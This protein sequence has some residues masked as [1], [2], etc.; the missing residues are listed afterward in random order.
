MVEGTP[1]VPY[2][3]LLACFNVV[4]ANMVVRRKEVQKMLKKYTSFV[5]G[6]SVLS[7]SFP[8]LGAPDFTSPPMKPTPTEDGPGRSIF[9]PED[10]VFCGHP[11]FKNLVKNIRGRRGEKVAINEDLSALGEGDM[12]SAAK[13][14]HIYM[15]HMGFGMG[16]CCLQSVDDRTAEERGL[17][18][19]K[20]SKWRIAKSRYDSTDC[21]IYPCSVAYNDIPLQYDEA[22]YQQLRDGD[23]DEPLAKHIA[24]MF[25]R[26][27]L[28]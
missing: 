19:L 2:G 8:S 11:R 24:H 1:G 13:P 26:D 25:I 7:I 16:C 4:E 21:Y 3:G 9:W 18:P 6:E 14:D 23:I 20:N 10:A 27:P 12:I 22:I 28:Q 5:Q 17:V 15:D